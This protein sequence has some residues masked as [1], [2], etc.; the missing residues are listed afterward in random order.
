[1][2]LVWLF[3]HETDFQGTFSRK[4]SSAFP[5]AEVSFL[6]LRLS[7]MGCQPFQSSRGPTHRSLCTCRAVAHVQMH[8]FC[9][10]SVSSPAMNTPG[11]WESRSPSSALYCLSSLLTKELLSLPGSEL[12]T[13]CVFTANVINA[14]LQSQLPLMAGGSMLNT[15]QFAFQYG[16]IKKTHTIKTKPSSTQPSFLAVCGETRAGE[17]ASALVQAWELPG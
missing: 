9:L 11:E 8:D 10:S 13:F 4:N 12:K 2:T 7:L 3:H 17:A 6:F 14:S 15:W 5:F 16:G 1:M